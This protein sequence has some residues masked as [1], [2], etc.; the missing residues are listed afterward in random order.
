MG[1]EECVLAR[2]PPGIARDTRAKGCGYFCVLSLSCIHVQQANKAKQECFFLFSLPS[3]LLFIQRIGII[4]QSAAKPPRLHTVVFLCEDIWHHLE[5]WLKRLAFL[6]L[7]NSPSA[8]RKEHSDSSIR[9][10]V[11]ASEK[12]K[13]CRL[14]Q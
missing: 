9:G 12:L 14:S 7:F 1:G 11:N 10:H 8:K 13:Y 2:C 4:F 5:G 6:L 3:F